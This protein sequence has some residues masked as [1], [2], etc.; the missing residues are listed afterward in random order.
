MLRAK[1]NRLLAILSL[2]LVLLLCAAAY[3]QWYSLRGAEL[4]QSRMSNMLDAA[5]QDSESKSAQLFDQLQLLR[6]KEADPLLAEYAPVQWLSDLQS[7]L[8]GVRASVLVNKT[9]SLSEFRDFEL[10]RVPIELELRS[11]RSSALV[12]VLNGIG[13][14]M[15]AY[16]AVDSCLL[17]K[18][19]SAGVSD[20]YRVR[21]RLM[22]YA[23]R[24]SAQL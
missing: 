22:K 1:R 12:L 4:E 14:S 6:Q 23:Y 2:I 21:C 17:A 24:K 13:T 9:E 7:A 10:I 8:V 20:G 16:T 3:W 15:G 19:Q 11:S 5:L 18:Q